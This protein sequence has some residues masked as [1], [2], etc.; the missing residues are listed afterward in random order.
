MCLS[1]DRAGVAEL[2]DAPDLGSGAFKRKS[3]NLFVRTNPPYPPFRGYMRVWLNGRAP[4]F[5]AGCVGSIP[6]TRSTTA[7]IGEGIKTSR[8]QCRLVY[9]LCIYHSLFD[10]Y[11]IKTCRKK[12]QL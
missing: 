5:Q 9:L 11:L 1:A 4:A 8:Q 7:L 10:P 2:A 12:Y 3:S 6:I